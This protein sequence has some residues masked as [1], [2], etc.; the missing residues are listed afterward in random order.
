V[1]SLQPEVEHLDHYV[2][3]RT[4]IAGTFA[5]EELDKRDGD[6]GNFE[7]TEEDLIPSLP[8]KGRSRAA[9]RPHGH[10]ARQSCSARGT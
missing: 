5:R 6:V 9:G 7:F 8:Q 4:W 10:Y 3:G 2:R 1:P